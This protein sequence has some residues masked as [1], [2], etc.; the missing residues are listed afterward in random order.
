MTTGGTDLASAELNNT[1]GWTL[2]S[3][4]ATCPGTPV[5]GLPHARHTA[6]LLPDGTVLLVGGNVSGP[7]TEIYDPASKTF[8]S[9]PAIRDRSFHTAT[10]V[11]PTATNLMATPSP[12]TFGQSVNL[13]AS[14]T[15]GSA[16]RQGLCISWTA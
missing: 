5:H 11:V 16:R 4:T 10:L 15:S 14:V 6:T 12:S 8:T 3:G 9:G 7:E 13:A 2:L 1:A